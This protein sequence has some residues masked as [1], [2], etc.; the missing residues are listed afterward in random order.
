MSDII[1]DNAVRLKSRASNVDI[2]T[3]KLGIWWLTVSSVDNAHGV[4]PNVARHALY[5]DA[6]KYHKHMCAVAQG[7]YSHI[8]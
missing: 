7:Y 4:E 5:E 8:F 2:Y 3:F 6:V 1:W